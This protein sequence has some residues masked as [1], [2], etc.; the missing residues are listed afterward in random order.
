[1]ALRVPG[2]G[3]EL[4]YDESGA[5]PS[6]LLVH[7][8]ALTRLSWRETVE[9]LGGG[10]RAIA[11]DRRGY[12]D[13]DTPEPYAATSIEEQAEDAAALVRALEAA[14]AVVCGHSC[15]AVVALDLLLRHRDLVR[16][17]VLIEPP[18]L[19]LSPQGEQ[20]LG[21]V[22]EAV[23]EAARKGGV[24]A[25]VEALAESQ[26]G[27]GLLEAVGAERAEAIR[28]S[29]RGAFADF[30]AASAWAF[31]RRELRVIEAPVTV[32]RGARASPVNREV[33]EEVAGLIGSAQLRELDAGHAAPLDDPAGVA[34]AVRELAASD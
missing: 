7:G 26:H 28:A 3:V 31:S 17:A 18:L 1:M 6:V 13:S 24:H 25:A 9:A 10:V 14:P 21:E 16:G 4:A 30:G 33:A 27:P 20:T 11:Y 22:R 23:A 29:A 5:G 15:G 12:G 8:T 19:S 32:L 34:A 2:A